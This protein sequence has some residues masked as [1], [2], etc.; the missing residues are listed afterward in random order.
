MRRKERGRLF[1][2]GQGLVEYAMVIIL[3]GIVVVL[4]GIVFGDNVKKFYCQGVYAVDPT[5]DAPGC[6]Y[7]EMS[8]V[9]LGTRPGQVNVRADVTDSAGDDD[10]ETVAFSIDGVSNGRPPERFVAYCYSGGDNA[11]CAYASAP[12]GTH[13][14][15]AI[16]T[17]AE[18]NTGQCSIEVTIP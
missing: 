13:T 11:S 1:E 8:C 18:N 7:I 2:E 17:D 6:E 9:L 12:S 15:S 5:V 16:A 14:I 4:I 3:V 10:I